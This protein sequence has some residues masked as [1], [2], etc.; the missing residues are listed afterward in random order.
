MPAP[1]CGVLTAA[2]SQRGGGLDSLN[3]EQSSRGRVPHLEGRVSGGPGVHCPCPGLPCLAKHCPWWSR[4]G[5]QEVSPCD[6]LP[7]PVT[8]EPESFG[9]ML[10]LSWRGTK[11]IELGN[12]QTRKFLLDGDEVIITG[13]GSHAP[14]CISLLS[15]AV[16][17]AVQP[18][19]LLGSTPAFPG[20]CLLALSL[21]PA[22]ATR[23]F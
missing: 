10:E 7:F 9:S 15:C 6:I 4:Q 2:C 19:V 5:H 1:S 16:P 11:P 13:E 17:L 18:S 8:K 3:P 20:L 14:S 12:G 22:L 21:A 23:S